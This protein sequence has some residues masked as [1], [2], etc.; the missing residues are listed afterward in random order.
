MMSVQKGRIEL[1]GGKMPLLIQRCPWRLIFS[2]VT[3]ISPILTAQDQFSR[4]VALANETQVQNDFFAVTSKH[5]V[6]P[7]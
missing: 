3:D 6:H 1:Q 4:I 2:R 5:G 7:L